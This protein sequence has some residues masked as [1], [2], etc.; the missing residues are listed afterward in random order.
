MSI[1]PHQRYVST[2]CFEDR[3]P[4][5][6]RAQSERCVGVEFSFL[7]CSRDEALDCAEQVVKQG[8]PVVLHNYFPPPEEPFVL[9]LAS[10]TPE[11]LEASRR[12]CREAINWTAAHGG[13][14]YAAHAG[15]V[16][17]LPD[18]IL[19]K[20]EQQRELD[21]AGFCDR[22]VARETFYESVLELTR[23]GK[24]CGVR[25]LIE[26]HVVAQESGET[27]RELLLMVDAREFLDLERYLSEQGEAAGMLLDVGH[28]KVSSR[29]C[30]FK[31]ERFMDEVQHL[32]AAYHLSDNDG[33]RDQHRPFDASAWFL[34]WVAETTRPCTLEFN[35]VDPVVVEQAWEVLSSK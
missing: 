32:A 35:R 7:N 24:A 12:M 21:P 13:D 29:S 8:T 14:F 17:D 15:Y 23:H 10:Q 30:G 16:A 27:G 28:L 2:S 18:E 25:F 6:I 4:A 26:N 31:R 11:I 3:S 20:P 19:G 5:G 33:C 22:E 1:K 9:N 34:P